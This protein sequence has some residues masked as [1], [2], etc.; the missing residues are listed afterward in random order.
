MR[1]P[2]AEP[3]SATAHGVDADR[4]VFLRRFR[5]QRTTSGLYQFSPVTSQLAK[6]QFHI[7][8]FQKGLLQS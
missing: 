2:N 8:Q 4:S 6:A 1:Y 3:C 7:L 5:R